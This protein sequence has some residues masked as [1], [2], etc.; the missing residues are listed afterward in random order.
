MKTCE[1]C[2]KLNPD[3]ALQ[4]E[5]CLGTSFVQKCANCG[6][7]FTEGQFCPHCGVKVGQKPKIC[8]EC[9]A[10][11]FSAACPDCGYTPTRAWH[12]AQQQTASDF[13][14]KP[15]R[16]TVL[17]VL[18]W[19]FCFPVPLTVLI[20]RS[21]MKTWA[22]VVLIALLWLFILGIGSQE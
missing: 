1:Y 17:W 8:P 20:A 18:G 4:C 12:P 16:H 13:T 14:P 10:E 19:I 22:K 9:G 15:K 2:G 21:R 3:D 7:E 6:A 11:Y 5:S